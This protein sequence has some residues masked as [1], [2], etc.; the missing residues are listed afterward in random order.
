MNRRVMGSDFTADILG[1]NGSK[2]QQLSFR[3]SHFVSVVLGEMLVKIILSKT[4]MRLLL[5]LT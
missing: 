2:Y 4:G 1:E 5:Y 3:R